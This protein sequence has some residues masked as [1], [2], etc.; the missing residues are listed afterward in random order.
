MTDTAQLRKLAEAS[1]AVYKLALFDAADTID[2]LTAERDAL[3][4]AVKAMVDDGWLY[5]G[6]EGMSDPQK[7]VYAAMKE[8]S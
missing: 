6:P 7:L 3:K 4:T 2:R 5:H 8:Q 1:A